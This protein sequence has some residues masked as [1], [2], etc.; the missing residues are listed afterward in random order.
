[1]IEHHFTAGATYAISD[2]WEVS[3]SAYFAPKVTQTDPGTGDMFSQFGG[4]TVI[5]MKQYGGQVGLR[6]KF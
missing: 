2:R 3:G 4:G 5:T 6:W 1:M